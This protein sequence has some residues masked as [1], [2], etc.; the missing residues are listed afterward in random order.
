MIVLW[1]ALCFGKSVV[2]AQDNREIREDDRYDFHTL[3]QNHAYT[4]GAPAPEIRPSF[5]SRRVTLTPNPTSG[6]AWV[7]KNFAV[8]A[9]V[10]ALFGL[11]VTS[12]SLP[13]IIRFL[14][15]MTTEEAW[16]VVNEINALQFTFVIPQNMA[17]EIMTAVKNGEL[18]A[19]NITT[20]IIPHKKHVSFANN[21]SETETMDASDSL[22]IDENCE[23]VRGGMASGMRAKL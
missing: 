9:Q 12:D 14:H 2:I 3:Y 7:K 5:E 8:V 17:V 16:G 19:N 23:I 13:Q 22:A 20:S 21:D 4:F 10:I 15:T 6:D 1:L 11:P 18:S